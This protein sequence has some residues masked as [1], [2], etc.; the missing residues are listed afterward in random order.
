MAEYILI[1]MLVGINLFA[2]FGGAIVI[3]R[4]LEVLNERPKKFLR[5][6]FLLVGMYFIEC[7]AFSAGM[8]TQIF[9]VGL[10]FIW[11]VILGFQ[12]SRRPE[13]RAILKT[14]FCISVYTSLPTAS[15][16]ILIPIVELF[17]ERNVISAAD[18]ASF[19]IPDFLPWPLNT[20]LGFC[21][22]LVTGTLVSK[23]IITCGCVK[24]INQS[25]T[26]EVK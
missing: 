22:A 20:I 13:I 25:R 18:G 15:F 12:F 9:T 11:G 5:Y 21:L 26:G 19:G 6:F 7:V 16:C 24:I 2:G 14:V 4:Q 23:I 10:A 17:G 3:A 8:C 1:F